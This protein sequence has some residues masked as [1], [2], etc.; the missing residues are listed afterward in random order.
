M[1]PTTRLTSSCG[2]SLRRVGRVP[3]VR[4]VAEGAFFVPSYSVVTLENRYSP[5]AVSGIPVVEGDGDSDVDEYG[6]PIDAP[7]VLGTPLEVRGA[8]QD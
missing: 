4:A 3:R 2:N 8:N 1:R 5:V 7:E 6:F